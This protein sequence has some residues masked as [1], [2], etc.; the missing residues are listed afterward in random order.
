[1]LMYAQ[2]VEQMIGTKIELQTK[3]YISFPRRRFM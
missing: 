2:S 3:R 1:M